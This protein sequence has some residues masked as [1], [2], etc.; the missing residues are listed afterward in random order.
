MR[1]FGQDMRPSDLN[2]LT[3]NGREFLVA[4][5]GQE[6]NIMLWDVEQGKSQVVFQ[7]TEKTSKV[8]SVIDEKTVALCE[9]RP[10]PQDNFIVY[11]LN[12]EGSQWKVKNTLLVE[13]WCKDIYDVC[14]MKAMD[15]VSS[16]IMCSLADKCVFSVDLIGGRIRWQK[17]LVDMG[18]EFQP[19][20]VCADDGDHVFVANL[21][22]G[23]VQ[24]LSGDDGGEI[25]RI[26]SL[27]QKLVS[28]TSVYIFGHYLY[29]SH[30]DENNEKWKISKINL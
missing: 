22:E 28:P 14:Y 10:N 19:M 2:F 27:P 4:V 12:T 18:P 17:S 29:V 11:I 26:P 30:R 23:C 1:H 25:H 21:K 20:S 9:Q 5:Y 3:R 16:L 24:I 15:N 8:F 7:T 6:G 13:V